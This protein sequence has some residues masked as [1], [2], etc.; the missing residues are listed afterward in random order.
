[1][2]PELLSSLAG[3]VLSLLFSYVPGLSTWYARLD[4]QYKSLS[5]VVLLLLTAGG[6]FGLACAG[7]LASVTCDQAGG[8]QMIKIFVAAL[9]ANQAAYILSPQTASVK[10]A[11]AER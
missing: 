7:L 3:I 8:I 2:T 1:M 11:K 4:T 5:M 9:I 10:A 6:V